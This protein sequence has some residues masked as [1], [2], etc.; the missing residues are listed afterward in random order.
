M[1][2][3]KIRNHIMI[4]HSL[5]HP[6]FGV[7]SQLHGATY[8][9]DAI[10]SGPDLNEMNVLIDIEVASKILHQVLKELHYKNLDLIPAFKNKITTTE[11]LA[12]YIHNQIS[13]NTEL[14][15]AGY[16]KV[17]LGESHIAW[18]AYESAINSL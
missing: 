16:L 6:G 9:V 7:A 5:A 17:E 12:Y 10:F 3:V 14:N 1:Y 18:A 4:A 11:F 8:V 15:F 13:S 2:S